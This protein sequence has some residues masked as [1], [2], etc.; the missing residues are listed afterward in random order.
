MGSLAFA[1]FPELEDE[2]IQHA[3][4]FAAAN[5]DDKTVCLGQGDRSNF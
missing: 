5:L 1:G 2:D 3:L 4:A